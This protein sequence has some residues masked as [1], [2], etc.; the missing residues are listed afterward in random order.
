M[1]KKSWV[2]SKAEVTHMIAYE[3]F[4]KYF[5]HIDMILI[6]KSFKADVF[7]HPRTPIQC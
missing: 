6:F 7:A 3:S 4:F 1:V 5:F 2:T